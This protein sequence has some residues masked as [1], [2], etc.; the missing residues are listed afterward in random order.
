MQRRILPL[1]LVLLVCS[2]SA[3]AQT[4]IESESKVVV[5]DRIAT[6]NIVVAGSSDLS[7]ITSSVELI[8][9]AGTVRARASKFVV[10]DLGG[11]QSLSFEMAVTDILSSV[12]DDI[13]WYRLHYTVGQ[14]SGIISMSQMIDELFELRIIASDNLLTGMSYRVRVRAVNPFTE[15]PAVGVR[16][17]STVALELAGEGE[18]KLEL[19]GSAVTDADGF[20][21]VD[22]AIPTEAKLAGEGEITVIGLKNGIVREANENL[23]AL[24][25]DVQFLT[26]TDKSIYQPE[27]LINI[28]GILMK[29]GE[30]KTVVA[31]SELEFRVLDEDDTVLYREKT[32]SSAFGIASISWRIPANA[33][34]GDYKIEIRDESGEQIGAQRVRVSR[35]DLPNFVVNA[36]PSKP[37]YLPGDREAE[38]EINADYLF[39]KP[40]TGGK[41]R[42]VEETSREWNYKEQKYDI[43][44]G[45]VRQGSTDSQGKFTAR[46]DVKK[47]LDGLDEDDWRKY[48]DINYA[49]YF[50]DLTTNRTEQRRFDIRVSREPIHVYLIGATNDLNPTMPIDAYV[51]TFYA[52]G[53][54]AECDVEVKMG[55]E[56]KGNPKT[57]ERIRTNSY[58]V[59]KITMDRPKI[60]D[61]DDDL[62]YKLIA[63]DKD[64]RQ[65]TAKDDISFDEDEAAIRLETDKAIYKPGETMSVNVSST[66]KTGPLYVDIVN[67]WSVVE[68]RFAHL[69]DGRVELQIPYSDKFKGELK[70]VAFAED[71][72]DD[73]V[74]G[75]RGVIFP[76]REG[77][78]VEATFDKDIYKPGEEATISYGVL[79]RLGTAVESALGVTIIDRAVEERARTDS[80]FGGIWSNYAGW[81]GYGSGLGAVNV[82]DLNELDLTK[83]ITDDLQLVAEV[84]LHDSYYKPNVFHSNSYFD[85][86]KSVFSDRITKQF[87]PVGAALKLTYETANYRHAVD[88]ES[89]EAILLE[90]DIRFGQMLDPWGV[91]YRAKFSVE[92]ARDIVTIVSAGP[93]K[94][95]DTK[96]D[97]TAFTTGFDYFKGTGEAIDNAVK[98]YH[99]RTGSFIRDEKTL[100]AELGVSGL[101]DRFGRPYRITFDAER[102]FYR[103][104]IRSGGSDGKFEKYD[105]GGDDFTVWTNLIDYFVDTETKIADIQRSLRVIPMNETDL[106]STLLAGGI[107]FG[108]L[109]DGFGDPLY[110]VTQ[111]RSRYWD[112]VTTE[113]VQNYGEDT[114]TDRRKVTP[115]TQ[116]VIEFTI[117]SNGPDRKQGTYDDLT[118]MQI[119]HV[120]SEQGKDDPKPIS[121]IRPIA[122]TASTG[123]IAGTV[124]DSNGAVIASAK[125]KVTN[126]ATSIDRSGTSNAEGNYLI[127]SLD[128]GTY[129]LRVSFDGFKDSVIENIP[130]KANAT[131]KVDVT[132]EVGSVSSAVD[133]T[134]GGDLM[135]ETSSSAV[136]T[137][138]DGA[139][140]ST[141]NFSALLKLKPGT[142]QTAKESSTPRL[143]EYFPETLV[144]QPEL[145][146]D[147][148]GKAALKF[149]MADNIT[150]WKMYVIASTKNGKIGVAESSV[151][152]FQSFFVD[153]DPPKFLTVGDEIFLPT[154]VRNYTQTKQRV[155]VKMD[156]ANWFTS[157][158]AGTQ[159]IEVGAGES[160][161]AV[162]GF[163]ANIPVNGGKQRVTATAASD[164][165]AIE[166]P[167]TVR[168]DG[169]EIVRTDSKIASGTQRFDLT[170]PSNA[171]T[172]TQKAELK[173]Y[174]NLYSH[175]A[176]SVEGLLER[177]YGC[178]EQTVSSTYPNLMLLK[179]AKPGSPI[180]VKAQNYL[181]KGYERL[182]GYQ[183][184]D[185]GFTYWGGKDTSD[186]ALTAYA[187]R[188]LNDAGSQITV[189]DD[190]IKRASTWLIKQ[191]RADGSWAKRYNWETAEDTG[192]TKM[193]TTYI[194][195]SLA[196]NK[197][198]DK[199]V[200]KPALDYLRARNNEID[201]PYA[202]A[203][204][205][206]A[207]L[208]SGDRA[209][210]ED[211]AS[212][213]ESMAISEGDGVYWKLETNTPFYGWGTAGRIETTAL[214]TQLLI[215]VRKDKPTERT[216]ELISKGTIF[217]L[218]NKDRY[219]VWYSTQTTINV[220]D[221][222]LAAIGDAKTIQA[223]R[224]EITLNGQPFKTVDVAADRIEP[225]IFDLTGK[226][227][228]ATNAIEV[229]TT[230]SAPM[231]TQTVAT[232][233]IEWKD[234]DLSARS[235]NQSRALKLDYQCD[236]QAP[237]IM[238]EVNCTVRA[239]RVGF[240][241]Y[242]MLLAE[243]GTPPGADVS[244]ESLEK[245]IAADGSISRYDVL[246]DRIVIYMWSRAGG[247][248][249]NFKFKPRY[250]V[251]AKTP[252]STIYDYYNPEAQA[253]APP[254]RFTVK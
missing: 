50:T 160:K 92:K 94:S 210:A 187:I 126:V 253:V 246:P 144:W 149:K 221:A 85:E 209:A 254:L 245:A 179:F 11:K 135:M 240:Q 93:D 145:L 211:V 169:Q 224:L 13:A 59:G 186:V 33:K 139:Q 161:N 131:A 62:E 26:M 223:Q 99:A 37:Y 43:D 123:S 66:L 125:I 102:R 15:K 17:D 232:H 36:K 49:A 101:A 182:L 217:L 108:G 95:F 166:R 192:R 109:R 127:T 107:D 14:A 106:R 4:V 197:D 69:K 5:R 143:R 196:M 222:F 29:G 250:G 121:I 25:E 64:G 247:T 237:A 208:D 200:L 213:L 96:D 61:P 120:L 24:K 159:Q 244:R 2:F 235:V 236:K 220:L 132:L 22:L 65:G 154:Q 158:G 60:G 9:P 6:A 242:G 181:Q 225:V 174:P 100:F 21:V 54:P 39:G 178:G 230:A 86:A 84:I 42:V 251:N 19:K 170:F 238:Q 150:T 233:Y 41:V 138:V 215:K 157:L 104:Q 32:R 198:A 177:P 234:A 1:F 28:R 40:V 241:G 164:A 20:A 122:Y 165:D 98:S 38:I 184:A 23:N 116:Q 16:V 12:K 7:G 156:A 128:A 146:T 53:T 202:L 80:E 162:F 111:Q 191:Q 130:V 73:V 137:T 34:L 55:V 10:T 71:T 148:N 8:D 227:D 76:I 175:V 118:L 252:A 231:M 103:F 56:D 193:I 134:S 206:L 119:V 176:E 51:S 70:I 229:R 207:S 212:R 249:I 75:S 79:D 173:V 82:K 243:I 67:G 90:S 45:E 105:W 110:I 72:D 115:V 171:I 52:D 201:E 46:F 228:S 188:F 81:L 91:A 239:E 147:S 133:V 205:G 219:G 88:L 168:P 58:G 63:K 185:G 248:N 83:P 129:K 44:E 124:T 30:S 48:R 226:L 204:Y 47:A 180:A 77:I 113:S 216:A 199:S 163:R 87:E 218:K 195:R 89:F 172:A 183:A 112:K 155:G 31:D 153:L 97:F 141:L 140:G 117:R 74:S 3:A 167:V 136:S 114:K 189:D 152:A 203:L 151:T 57:V 27:Q 142:V 214:V 18:R 68:S 194:A 190:V 78:S 35:Y